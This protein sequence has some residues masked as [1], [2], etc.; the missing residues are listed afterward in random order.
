MVDQV[1]GVERRQIRQE[2]RMEKVCDAPSR[3]HRRELTPQALRLNAYRELVP[4]SKPRPPQ[5]PAWRIVDPHIVDAGKAS[6]YGCATPFITTTV[7]YRPGSGRVYDRPAMAQPRQQLLAIYPLPVPIVGG[8]RNY[9]CIAA[10]GHMELA[11]AC[12]SAATIRAW[13]GSSR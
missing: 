11:V 2:E 10:V 4:A 9:P 12:A 3:A 5:E 8:E 7:P 6:S 1:L 13:V